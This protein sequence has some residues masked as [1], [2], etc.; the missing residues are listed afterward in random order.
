MAILM[1]LNAK[2]M[3]KEAK[4]FN[5]KLAP[6]LRYELVDMK[7]IITSGDYSFNIE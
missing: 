7:R 6:E 1:Y 2:E 5:G 3:V 4:I